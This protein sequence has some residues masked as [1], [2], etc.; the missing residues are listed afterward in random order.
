MHYTAIGID[1]CNAPHV[2]H[3][4]IRA[5]PLD[6]SGFD[7]T[8]MVYGDECMEIMRWRWMVSHFCARKRFYVTV[9]DLALYVSYSSSTVVVVERCMNFM[10]L[11]PLHPR[12]SHVFIR[13]Q[14][15]DIS[16][17]HQCWVIE[18]RRI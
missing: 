3:G 2:W 13:L 11:H 7:P 10:Q 1:G 15:Y 14:R 6:D 18:T 4:T 9:L 16:V 12:S 17:T 5:T 8:G